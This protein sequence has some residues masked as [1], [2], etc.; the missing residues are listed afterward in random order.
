MPGQD[1]VQGVLED[2]VAGPAGRAPAARLLDEEV[3]E[4]RDDF[5][6]V[7][8]GADDDDRP[9]R[10]QVLEAQLPVEP[11]RR[12]AHSGRAAHLD[13]LGTGRSDLGQEVADAQPEVDFIDARALAVPGNAQQLGPGGLGRAQRP[14]PVRAPDHD[15][16]RGAERLDV[17]DRGRL[18]LIAALDGEGRPV[19]WL[20][21]LALG[22]LEQGGLFPADVGSGAQLDLDVEMKILA[23]ARVLA[24]QARLAQVG[25]DVLEMGFE[26][27]VLGPEVEHTQLGADGVA[28]YGHAFEE[29]SGKLG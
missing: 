12:D 15:P 5:E 16:G 24:Q 25:Q 18:A 8:A 13:G 22:R 20:A 1:L 28:R 23:A 26:V 11:G 3:H 9:A 29:Q 14:E 17:I 4:V 6:Q 27:G 21:P 7:P 10:G 2:H 19:A